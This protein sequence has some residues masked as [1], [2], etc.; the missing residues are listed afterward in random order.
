M[1]AKIHVA[2]TIPAGSDLSLDDSKDLP[3][4][5][6]IDA[7]KRSRW[8]TGTFVI[9]NAG[10]DNMPVEALWCG[11]S[12]RAYKTRADIALDRSKGAAPKARQ[13][14][15]AGADGRLVCN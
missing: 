9:L 6:E 12:E 4:V 2:A 7:S 10:Q 15:C 8:G 1:P 5:C 3:K 13:I 11:I 14:A